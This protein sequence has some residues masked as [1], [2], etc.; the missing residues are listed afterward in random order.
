MPAAASGAGRASALNCGLVR[1]RGT[2]RMSTSRSTPAAWISSI[3]SP[4]ERVACPIVKIVPLPA[5][6][7]REGPVAQRREGEGLSFP[8]TLTRPRLHLGH[9]LPPAHLRCA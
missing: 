8:T 2:E 7:E 4:T 9:P 3:S 1:E 6:R 5:L